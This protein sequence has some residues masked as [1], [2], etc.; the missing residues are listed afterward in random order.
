MISIE[1]CRK[2]D[3]RLNNLSDEEVIQVREELYQ[4]AILALESWAKENSGS[5]NLE[6]LLLN[7]V[8]GIR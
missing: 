8:E 3:P 5:K 2:I 6:W 4:G 7:K 1:Q